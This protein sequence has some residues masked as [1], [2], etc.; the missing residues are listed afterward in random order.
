[1][2]AIQKY[3]SSL[4]P[5]LIVFMSMSL[6]GCGSGQCSS[7]LVM[8]PGD[9]DEEVDLGRIPTELRATVTRS[10]EKTQHYRQKAKEVDQE[11]EKADKE[12]EIQEQKNGSEIA[13]LRTQLTSNM[14]QLGVSLDEINKALGSSASTQEQDHL[15]RRERLLQEIRDQGSTLLQEIKEQRRTQSHE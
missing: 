5:M 12:L 1:M 13:Q 7:V 8:R 4:I 14:L 9:S 15:S 10:T 11:L 3:R 6:S 2:G